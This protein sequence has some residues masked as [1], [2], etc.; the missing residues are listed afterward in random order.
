M[1]AMNNSISQSTKTTAYEMDFEQ[2]LRID[3]DFWQERHKQSKNTTI[4]NEEDIDDS[5]VNDLKFV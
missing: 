1:L 3:H 2:A 4:M 5:I